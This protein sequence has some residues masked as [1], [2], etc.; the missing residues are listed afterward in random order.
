MQNGPVV[1]AMS[2]RLQLLLLQAIIV[3]VVTVATGGVAF[4]LQERL[5]RDQAK[6]R[7]LGVA[8]SIAR[9][10]VILD[11]LHT[12]DPS[13]VIQPVAEV[14]RESS[15][16]TYVV[17]TDVDGIRF[18]HPNPERIGEKVSTD[19]SVPLSGEIYEGTQL[20]TLGL[21]WRVKAPIYG[22]DGAD[23][24]DGEV[25]GSV[26]VGILESDL[27]AD[28]QAWSPWLLGAVAG[29]AIV[30][31]F[32]AAGVTAIV[33]RRIFKLEPDQIAELVNER[34]TMLHR[35]SEGVITVD[36]AGVI[37]LANDAALRLLDRDAILGVRAADVLEGPVLDVLENGE[38]DGRLVL[39][40][41]RAVIA[42]GTGIR[43]DE[44]T[45]V[46]GTLLLRD[47]TELH[48]ALRDMDGAQSLTDG[49]RAQAH[50]FANSMHVVAGLLEMRRVD[51]AR[52]FIARVRPGGPLH[53]DDPTA[54][55]SG[56]L[57]AILSVKTV[58]ARERGMALEVTASGKVPEEAARDLVTVV[59]NLVDNAMEA[60]SVGDRITVSLLATAEGVTVRVDDSGP[61]VPE[62]SEEAIF[63][64]GTTTKEGLAHRRGIG[65]ALVARIA[66]RRGGQVAVARSEA[67]G[68]SFVMVLPTRAPV[69]GS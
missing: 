23:G 51:E 56:E 45:V 52:D 53:V 62:G 43:D 48:A 68:A 5:I 47:H 66:R 20:G 46:G 32:G 4:A 6:E 67:G 54:Q 50:E 38:P 65:L 7:M 40:G 29:S 34:E 64:E 42:R 11:A 1:R 58:Q 44:G 8:L 16:L 31:V 49:L 63:A 30:G 21:S 59:G 10:P 41:E 27:A 13:A 28:L 37:T 69:V 18:S 61:G 14:I 35:L 36:A 22:A 9:L 3:C 12:D 24:E 39:A 26:S 25:I 17:V 57:A 2:L 55:L 33:R 15:D 19:P 60:C